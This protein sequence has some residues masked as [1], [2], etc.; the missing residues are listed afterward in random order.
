[1][2]SSSTRAL[3]HAF[4]LGLL[5]TLLFWSFYTTLAF[6][7]TPELFI[8]I[9]GLIDCSLV[10]FSR[11]GN[12]GTRGRSLR[13]CLLFVVINFFVRTL[14]NVCVFVHCLKPLLQLKVGCHGTVVVTT[15]RLLGDSR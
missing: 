4:L 11:F 10:V 1:M 15:L 8:H 9:G 7:L 2:H 14:L 12:R 13:A 3:L 6:F 5:A